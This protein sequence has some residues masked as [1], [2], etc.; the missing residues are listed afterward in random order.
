MT[1]LDASGRNPDTASRV[2]FRTAGLPLCHAARQARKIR[3]L[4]RLAGRHV[5]D[6]D[7]IDGRR[8]CLCGSRLAAVLKQGVLAAQPFD[9]VTR[10]PTGAPMVLPDEPSSILDVVNS[11]TAGIITSVS[12]TGRW[13]ISPR[14]PST[15]PRCGTGPTV[16]AGEPQ[17]APGPLRH[18]VLSPDGAYAIVARSVSPS[19]SSLW[20]VDLARGSIAPF[21]TG[22]ARNDTAVWSPDG[23]RVVFAADR[24]GPQDLYL[25]HSAVQTPERPLYRSDAPF[26]APYGWSPDGRWIIMSQLDN[27]T[28][29]NV[30]LISATGARTP[31]DRRWTASRSRRR[32]I[33][34][35]PLARLHLRP[36]RTAR[37]V[38]PAAHG[39]GVRQQ[40]SHQGAATA[41]WTRDGRQ[42]IFADGNW[43][44]LWRVDVSARGPRSRSA[45]PG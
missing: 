32:A 3:D 4:R 36:D 22:P 23:T 41:W 13:P 1:T 27:Q 43:R 24:D 15:R 16:R 8:A 9:P 5:T 26:K 18:G 6:L 21:S 34:G 29:E 38:C 20:L 19:E 33:P 35:R 2:F 30:W 40:V 11:F 10:K 31:A 39:V 44:T 28:S 12:R 7:R 17:P 42:L 14:H 37:G 45:H 25:K